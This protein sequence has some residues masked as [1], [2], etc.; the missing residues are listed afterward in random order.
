MPELAFKKVLK[1]QEIVQAIEALSDNHLWIEDKSGQVL[2]AATASPVLTDAPRY[3]V[4][5]ADKIVGWA[6]GTEQAATMST[7]L[8]FLAQQELDKKELANALWEKNQEMSLF[9]DISTQITASLEVREV[10][11]LVIEEAGKIIPCTSGAIVLLNPYTDKLEVFAE[12]GKINIDQIMRLPNPKIL[13][14]IFESGTG[15]IINDTSSD[16]RCDASDF[17][18]HSLICVPLKTKDRVIGLVEVGSEVEILYTPHDLKL[19][20]MFADQA[21]VSIEKAFLYEHSRNATAIAQETAEQL[22]QALVE[23]RQTQAQL[24]QSEKMSSLGELVA[25]VA[26]EINNPVNFISGNLQ[27]AEEYTKNLVEMLGLYQEKYTEILPEIE[28]FAEEIELDYLLEDLPDLISSMRVGV[29]RICQIVLALRNFSRSDRGKMS[30]V[31]IHDGLDSTLFILKHRM[32]ETEL[33]GGIEIIRN[34]GEL[35]LVRCYAEQLNQVFMNLLSNAIDAIEDSKAAGH[36]APG[37]ERG[38]IYITTEASDNKTVTIRIRD[39]GFGMSEEVHS[40]LFNA[41]FTTKPIGKGTGLGLSISHQIITQKHR[42]TLN[43]FSKVGQ[44][45]EFVITLP[46]GRS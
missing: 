33:S 31:N 27:H 24:I 6:I 2:L 7:L 8:S 44:G 28:E 26:H 19:L 22:Q 9:Q 18:L 39:N 14:A 1:N 20:L 4:R 35:P 46:I 43:C 5:V 15:E 29:D 21:A 37:K 13:Q 41:F 45:T 12:F 10:A 36:F 42:G 17:S 16:D 11:N 34:Y 3:P 23:L 30:S 38:A 40:Q 25:G 32:K